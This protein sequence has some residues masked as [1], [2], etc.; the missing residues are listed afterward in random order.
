MI[1]TAVL[2]EVLLMVIL[3]MLLPL[4]RPI[5]IDFQEHPEFGGTFI[6]NTLQSKVLRNATTSTLPQH[7]ECSNKCYH[8]KRAP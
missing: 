1:M 6:R 7:S 3:T 2:H 5:K 4:I 8:F